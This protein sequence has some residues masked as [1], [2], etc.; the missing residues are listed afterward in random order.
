QSFE[1]EIKAGSGREE[2][3]AEAFHRAHRSRYGYAQSEN[4]VEIVSARLR[5]SGLV[6][7]LGD[8]RPPGTKSSGSRRLI[9]ERITPVNFD[10]KRRDVAVYTREA[11][12]AGARLRTP[13]VVTEY[14]STTLVP[15][16]AAAHV[17]AR[18]NLIIELSDE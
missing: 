1:L 12:P 2:S 6:E 18:G 13:C 9:P 17:D 14:S 16:D 15:A 10:D 3:L 11:L 8:E 7:K 5:S 4:S